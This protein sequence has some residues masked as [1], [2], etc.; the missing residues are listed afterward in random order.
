M[1]KAIFIFAL[2][3]PS[4]AMAEPFNGPYVGIQ[5]G[6]E[7][8]KAS[9]SDTGL[10]AFA[11]TSFRD[12][13]SLTGFNGGVFAGYGKH[14][15]NLY[16]GTEAEGSFS[17][18]D[19]RTNLTVGAGTIEIKLKHKYDYGASLKAGF[20]P[21]KDTLLYGKIGFIRGKFEDESVHADDVLTGAKFG[22]GTE[23]LVSSNI[24][25]RADWSYTNYGTAK[26]SDASQNGSADP[27]SSIF[28]LGLA[29]NF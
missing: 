22:I 17:N 1:K 19:S 28:R 21:V 3:L 27:S 25:A 26:Y 8:T 11:G 29:Y 24:T 10:G 18:A 16:I 5:G 20:F 14:V 13:I 12:D 15:N 23:T 6:Y 7:S 2:L 4:I 9:V